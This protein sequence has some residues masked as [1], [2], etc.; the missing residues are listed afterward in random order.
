[1]PS[2]YDVGRITSGMTNMNIDTSKPLPGGRSF[3]D[4]LQ[5]EVKAKAMPTIRQSSKEDDNW[6]TVETKRPEPSRPPKTNNRQL[7][8]P[9]AAA[10]SRSQ[11]YGK[12]TV[13]SSGGYKQEF[14]PPSQQDPKLLEAEKH[15]GIKLLKNFFRP[16][17]VFRAVLH[18]QDYTATSS[19]S[20]ITVAD[21]NRTPSIYGPIFTKVRHLIVLALYEDHY[22]AI[23]LFT[24]NKTGLA[25]KVKK[26]EFVSIRDKRD[27]N[28]IPA[29]SKHKPLKIDRVNP[30]IAGFDPL[31]TAHITYPLARKYDL[32]I[33]PEGSIEVESLNYLITLFNE[34]AAPK[35]G[36]GTPAKR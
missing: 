22:M 7:G 15:K 13:P 8:P 12:G 27:R 10:R 14:L 9:S 1:M 36:S 2:N 31:S 30:G 16:G 3:T 6:R 29:L 26:D 17:I 33:I 28:P 34:H 24:H 4:K 35:E 32:P 5:R 20:Q 18:D 19:G 21:K 23:P 11:V 25:G